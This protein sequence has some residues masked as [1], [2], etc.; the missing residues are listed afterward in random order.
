MNVIND[1]K[2]MLEKEF[3]DKKLLAELNI[4]EI[5]DN[6][7][8]LYRDISKLEDNYGDEFKELLILM[9]KF[10]SYKLILKMKI[11]GSVVP[12]S[13]DP[14]NKYVQ[15]R[16]AVIGLN[17]KRIWISHY[18]GPEGNYIGNNGKLIPVRIRNQGRIPVILKTI[19]KLLAQINEL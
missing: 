2:L 5:Q 3:I 11:R 17:K 7:E 6:V 18:L 14:E 15:A 19:E 4:P 8:Q 10:Y 12:D 1:Y 16:G 13:K 9:T